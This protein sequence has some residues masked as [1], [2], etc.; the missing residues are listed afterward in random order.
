MPG[1]DGELFLIFDSPWLK[2]LE[3]STVDFMQEEN[4]IEDREENLD[5]RFGLAFI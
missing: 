4:G 3:L 2:M 5:Y 1:T